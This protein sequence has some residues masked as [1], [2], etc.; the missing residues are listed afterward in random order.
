MIRIKKWWDDFEN[1]ASHKL[2][3]I[4]HFNAPTGNDSRGYRKLMRSGPEG[5]I[6]LGVFQA[7]CQCMAGLSL[8]AR[9]RGETINSDLSPLDL[10]DLADLTRL[11]IDLLSSAIDLLTSAAEWIE[12]LEPLENKESPNGPPSSPSNP[13]T[14]PQDNP[15]GEERRGGIGRGE[16]R[17]ESCPAEPPASPPMAEV[18]DFIWRNVP[19]VSRTRS[20]QKQLSDEWKR[21]KAGDRPSL[22]L[23]ETALDAWNN[24]SKWLEG[25][26]EGVHLWVKNKQWNNLPT[27]L[28][29]KKPEADLGNRIASIAKLENKTNKSEEE[30][31]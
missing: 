4:R 31:P 20:S 29:D 7:L 11:P 9:K 1:A 13:P 25:Y 5:V 2:K 24:C 26:A 6:A 28:P 21:T 3:T 18:L 12:P 8:E 22:E 19:Q 30:K 16:E 17:R 15:N 10:E 27:A 14:I 23:L